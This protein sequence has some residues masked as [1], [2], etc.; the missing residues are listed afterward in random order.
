MTN[1]VVTGDLTIKGHTE[2]ITF[3]AQI[4]SETDTRLVA[5]ASITLNRANWDIRYGS[6]TFFEDLGDSLID[7]KVG[8]TLHLV[9]TK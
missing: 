2:K 5:D 8:L 7:D 3:P 6:G 4:V 1:G 9:A